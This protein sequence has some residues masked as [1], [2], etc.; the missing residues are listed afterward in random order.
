M[1]HHS[2]LC[3]PTASPNASEHAWLLLSVPHPAIKKEEQGRKLN[4]HF[5]AHTTHTHIH[6]NTHHTY[7]HKHTLHSCM[8]LLMGKQRKSYPLWL[9]LIKKGRCGEPGCIECTTWR[10]LLRPC[11]P[12]L[13]ALLKVFVDSVA[14]GNHHRRAHNKHSSLVHCSA[15]NKKNKQKK[16]KKKKLPTAQNPFPKRKVATMTKS[17]GGGSVGNPLAHAVVKEH[18]TRALREVLRIRPQDPVG[19]L[20][21]YFV[22]V[23]TGLTAVQ[24]AYQLIRKPACFGVCLRLCCS[25]FVFGGWHASLAN[26][27]QYRHHVCAARCFCIGHANNRSPRLFREALSEAYVLLSVNQAH[28]LDRPYGSLRAK[29]K[30]ATESSQFAPSPPS[31]A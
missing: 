24:R 4:S 7:V 11:T 16:K 2:A 3:Y 9:R 31:A 28:T 21:N 13:F 6:T 14:N 25:C 5:N 30:A 19:F 27:Y 12:F 29:H 10:G 18:M 15:A 22:H 26:Q 8:W 17:G 1:R 20:A 23:T